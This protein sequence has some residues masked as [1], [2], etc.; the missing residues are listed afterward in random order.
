MPGEVA[1]VCLHNLSLGPPNSSF[2]GLRKGRALG[3]GGAI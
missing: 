2:L 3:K 1:L